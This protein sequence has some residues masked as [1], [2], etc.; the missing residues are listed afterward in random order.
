MQPLYAAIF[1]SPKVNQ[2]FRDEA[3]LQHMLRFESALAQAQAEQGLIPGGA[4]PIIDACCQVENIDKERL[5]AE[6]ALGGN[7][8]IPLIKQL[9]SVVKHRDAAAA[10]Y[11]HF[12]ATSQ[13]VIDSALMMQLRAATQVM[14]A[15]LN[16]LIHH[17]RELVE[18]HRNTVMIG[19]SF[20]QQARPITFG[21]KAA[22]WL[23]GLLRSRKRVEDLLAEN[24]VLQFGGAV[25]TLPGM[26]GKGLLVAET[27]AGLLGLN[28]PSIPWHTQRDRLAEVATTLGLLAGNLGKIAKDISLLMQTEIAEVFEPSGAGKGGSS[29]MP[30]KRNPVG[31]LA[32]LANAQRVP[33]LVATLLGSLVQDHERATGAWHAEWETLRDLVQLTAGALHQAVE[34]TDGLEVDK[35]QMGRN[36][37]LTHGLIFAENVS[38]ALAD[39][40]G[41]QESHQL[42]ENCCHAV[43]AK[44]GHLKE[45]LLDN[46]TVMQ[47]LTAAQMES[48]FDPAKSLGLSEEWINRVIEKVEV[49]H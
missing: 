4:A 35:S 12:G 5:I 39:K 34:V 47:H 17:L 37:E 10:K 29:T 31:C 3:I 22:N 27:M 25:G 36:I 49:S 9:T 13:D 48:L 24:F 21:F 1:Y 28:L 2:L 11:V 42:I 44:G 45:A 8:N 40:I 41:K 23:D 20:M 7:V 6:A 26:R 19:R 14:A 15:D 32:I 18:T 43:Q 33:S 30:H 16:L 38:L 46:P